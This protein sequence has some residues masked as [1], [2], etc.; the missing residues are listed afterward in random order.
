MVVNSDIIGFGNDGV[1]TALGKG[2]G[3]FVEKGLV[4]NN[5]GFNQGWR[6]ENHPRFVVDINGDGHAD[7]VGFGDAGVWTALSNRNGTFQEGRFVLNN[8]GFN[9]GWRVEKHPRFLTKLTSDNF[10]DIVGFGDAGVW[11]AL[12]KG[13]GTFVEKGLVVN[14]FGFNQGWRVENH[15][16]FVVDINDNGL[17]DIVGFGDAG[18][19]T[20]LG[21]GDGTFVEKGLVVNNFGFNQG[22][23][24]E[25]H[26]R[27]VANL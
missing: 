6:V 11:T 3:T 9:Q 23:R 7:I 27:F 13:D 15:P 2:D 24:V 10:L 12:G 21:K 16:R 25:N 1:W 22:W 18:V 17:A 20:A 14:N 4:V 19:W 5:F 8:F 26:P